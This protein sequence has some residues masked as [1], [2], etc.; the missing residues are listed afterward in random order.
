MSI[1]TMLLVVLFGAGIHALPVAAA[2]CPIPAHTPPAPEQIVDWYAKY[3]EP[4]HAF[5]GFPVEPRPAKNV[6]EALVEKLDGF[7]RRSALDPLF[8]EPLVQQ[9]AAA[10]T[11]VGDF[12]GLTTAAAEKIYRSGTGTS[13]DFSA[14]CIDTRRD[15]FPDDTFAITLS[16]VNNYNCTHVTLRGLVFSGILING[17][18][19]GECRPDYPFFRMLFVPVLAGTN[20]VT[21]LCGKDR[22]GCAGR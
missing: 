8:F 5:A 9:V 12:K 19:N 11:G 22:G 13:L 3:I 20:S 16:G 1:R 10:Y 18:I 14:L 17:T 6:V 21:F 15:R 4:A 2:D 7:H